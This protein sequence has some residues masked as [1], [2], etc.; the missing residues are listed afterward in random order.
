M[1]K[2]IDNL[3]SVAKLFQMLGHIFPLDTALSWGAAKP[4]TLNMGL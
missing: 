3:R 4:A 2:L 1:S